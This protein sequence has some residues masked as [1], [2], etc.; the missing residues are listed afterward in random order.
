MVPVLVS[1]DVDHRVL[2]LHSESLQVA[3]E[4]EVEVDALVGRA[5]EGTNAGVGRS[6]SR[7]G[8][9]VEEGQLWLAEALTGAGEVAAPH[10]V[11]FVERLHQ[12][13]V[14]VLEDAVSGVLRAL[15]RQRRAHTL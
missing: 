2:P 3:A 15:L 14:S 11:R 7:A 13:A 12:E 6:T 5:V 4:S 8:L 9:P 10:L 1:H